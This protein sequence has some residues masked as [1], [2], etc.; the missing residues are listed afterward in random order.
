MAASTESSPLLGQ[1]P[2]PPPRLTE[3]SHSAA[4]NKD[5]SKVNPLLLGQYC[6]DLAQGN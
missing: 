6:I 2:S 5:H 1:S 3:S 4:S